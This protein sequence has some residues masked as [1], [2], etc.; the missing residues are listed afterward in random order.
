MVV[1]GVDV[2]LRISGYA[3]CEVKNLDVSLIKEGEVKTKP[4]MSLPKKLFFI[5]KKFIDVINE[6]KPGVLV[7][8]KLYSHY[9][10]PTT[11]SLLAQVRGVTLLLAEEYDLEF[12][13]YSPTKARKSFLGRGSADSSRVKKMLEGMLGKPVL[14]QHTA[15]A[16]SLVVAFS[17]TLKIKRFQ[18]DW[19]NKR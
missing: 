13:E 1:L 17:H 8:E 16:F 9:R 10:H 4:S 3:V 18:D 15:D 11:V 14:S 6:Y 7:L 2:G 19:K 12:Y 5:H